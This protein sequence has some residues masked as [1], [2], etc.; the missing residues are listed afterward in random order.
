MA[1]LDRSYVKES[2]RQLAA[3]RTKTFG[4]VE[5]KF[6]LNPPVA[7]ADL[8]AF[9]LKHH[10][11]LPADYRHFL[12][13]I[14]NGGAGSFYGIFPLGTMDG[15]GGKLEAWAERDDF[16]GILAQPFPLTEAWNDLSGMPSAELIDTNEEEYGRQ[17][18]VFERKYF[19]SSYVN[20][21]I[22]ICHEGC[23]LRVWLV[24][25]GQQA[26]H[27]WLDDRANDMGIKPVLLT[28]GSRATFSFWYA[29]WLEGALRE[30]R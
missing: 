19:D 3:G 12:R 10:I 21:A 18:Q 28:D 14:G 11:H 30:L 29:E 5:H 17:L 26:G 8:V 2:L 24:V 9:E 16:V 22:P 23:A 13:E 15:L 27:L 7:E 4:A 25:T 1:T 20:G 6:L